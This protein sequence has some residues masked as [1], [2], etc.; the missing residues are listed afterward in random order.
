M[1]KILLLLALTFTTISCINDPKKSACLDV[2]A[3]ST[4]WS[5]IQFEKNSGNDQYAINITNGASISF[6]VSITSL[7]GVGMSLNCNT[8]VAAQNVN[9]DTVLFER[10]EADLD[11]FVQYCAPD[12]GDMGSGTTNL[13]VS[14]GFGSLSLAYAS[15]E[16]VTM[17]GM[18]WSNFE[19]RF[20]AFL[21][22]IQCDSAL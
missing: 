16:T 13:N 20:E 8:E 3:S 2:G 14:G 11:H 15:N 1:N 21:D 6:E 19:A 18:Q 17:D 7:N 5:T 4:D 10:V 22:S 9:F 12:E